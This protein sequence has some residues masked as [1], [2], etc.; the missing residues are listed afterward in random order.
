M[1]PADGGSAGG[2]RSAYKVADRRFP[3]EDGAA[4]VHPSD[5]VRRY[6][7][8]ESLLLPYITKL[9]PSSTLTIPKL[10]TRVVK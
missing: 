3:V 1:R 10:G 4:P 2:N 5:K 6:S 7:G 9:L 8:A